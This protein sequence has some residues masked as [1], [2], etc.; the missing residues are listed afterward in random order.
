MEVLK[1]DYN[2]PSPESIQKSI[3]VLKKDGV[4][5]APSD[6]CYGLIADIRC[7]KAISKVYELKNRD[8]SLPLSIVVN[9]KI[10]DKYVELTAEQKKVVEKYLPGSYTL[11]LPKTDLIPSYI[12]NNMG[13]VGIRMMNCSFIEKL[14]EFFG[15]PFITTSANLSGKEVKYNIS[16]VLA[17]V[18]NSLLDFV[19]DAGDLDE[20]MPSQVINILE[21][22]DL[23]VLRD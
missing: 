3:Q 16:K 13:N 8:K 6:T 1:I 20:N 14:S 2:N 11:I 21:N 10:L 4:I 7:K 23:E 5:L 18:D 22:G 9:P 19:I 17:E 15:F 12:N